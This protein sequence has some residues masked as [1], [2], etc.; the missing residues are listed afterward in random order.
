MK[1]VLL[2][3]DDSALD[4]FLGFIQ[5][6]PKVEV[7]NVADGNETQE[8]IDQCFKLA[9]ELL[10]IN[11]VFRKPGDYSYIMKAVNEGELC[12]V[13]PFFSPAEYIDYMSLLGIDN[14]PGKSTIYDNLQKI[15]GAYPNWTYK[16][17]KKEPANREIL[18]RKNIV[19]Q[20][21]SAF[22][23]AK[24]ELSEPASER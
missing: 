24:R 6:C 11:N 14:L 10:Q 2:R 22:F 15:E 8:L 18:R 1:E 13:D 12:N 5:L 3:I 21:K 19:V 17:E 23:K 4:Q 20:F 9:I 16:G 7:M